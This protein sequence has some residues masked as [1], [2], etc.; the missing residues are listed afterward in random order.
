M[1]QGCVPA[2]G[3]SRGWQSSSCPQSRPGARS[4]V[5]SR[6]WPSRSCALVG[7]APRAAVAGDNGGAQGGTWCRHL[8]APGAVTSLLL[9]PS[10]CHGGWVTMP[11]ATPALFVAP[12][13]CPAVTSRPAGP[14]L[15]RSRREL[16]P[17]LPAERDRP[18]GPEAGEHPAGRQREHQGEGLGCH[19]GRA[20][21]TGGDHNTSVPSGHVIPRALGI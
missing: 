16:T 1:A 5:H 3:G 11:G 10:W 14:A 4:A 6:A 2:L 12:L 18:P 9:L 7:L 20:G 17:A 8:P 15:P 13:P 19:P 21:G